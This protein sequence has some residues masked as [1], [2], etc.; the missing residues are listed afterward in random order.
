[1][2]VIKACEVAEYDYIIEFIQ[3]FNLAI[4]QNTEADI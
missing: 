1:M 4:K 2:N 3:H